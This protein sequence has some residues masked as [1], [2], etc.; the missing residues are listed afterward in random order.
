MNQELPFA[1]KQVNWN[2]LNNK[3]LNQNFPSF[4]KGYDLVVFNSSLQILMSHCGSVQEFKSWME[5]CVE[6]TVQRQGFLM[7]HE[8]TNNFDSVAELSKL[9][10]VVFGRA[11]EGIFIKHLKNI[12]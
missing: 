12:L 2:I 6:Q 3:Q 7:I 4:L 5:C 11:L 10:Q 8:F 1:V 9:E